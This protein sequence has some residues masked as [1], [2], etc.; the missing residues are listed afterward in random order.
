MIDLGG[1]SM[2]TGTMTTMVVIFIIYSLVIVGLGAYV[3][4]QSKKVA[5]DNL[6]SFLTAAAGSAPSPSP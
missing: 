6:A 1:F 3:K 2:T 5:S 4:L